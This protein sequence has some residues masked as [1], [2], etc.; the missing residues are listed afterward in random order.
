MSD[1]KDRAEHIQDEPGASCSSIK[2]GSAQNKNDG[3]ITMGNKI[4]LNE[5]PIPK[6]GKI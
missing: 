4:Q 1:S 3:G 5:F 6:A 2:K